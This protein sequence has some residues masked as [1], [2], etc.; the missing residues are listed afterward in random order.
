MQVLYDHITW[1]Q[2]H[3]RAQFR[4]DYKAKFKRDPYVNPVARLRWDM[5]SK[6]TSEHVDEIRNKRRHFQELVESIFGNN[7]VMLTP[8]LWGELNPRDHYR[9][10]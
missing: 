8:F 5:G 7:S 3:G 6:M 4:E 10:A 9:P 2:Y 1:G